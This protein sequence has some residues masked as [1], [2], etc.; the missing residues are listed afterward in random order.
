MGVHDVAGGRP[1]E[2]REAPV[3]RCN[4]GNGVSLI[5]YELSRRH[6]PRISKLGRFDDQSL[7]SFDRLGNQYAFDSTGG[8]ARHDLHA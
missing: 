2:Y 3:L 7:G 1:G 6:V 8:I 5:V 4:Q